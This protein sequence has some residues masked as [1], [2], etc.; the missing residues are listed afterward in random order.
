MRL[1][2]VSDGENI[3]D[4]V[5]TNTGDAGLLVQAALLNGVSI[6]D[7]IDIGTTL[8]VQPFSIPAKTIVLSTAVKKIPPATIADGQ[9]LV[10]LAM[11]YLGDAGRLVELALLNGNSITDEPDTG[12]AVSIPGVVDITKQFIV[13][14]FIKWKQYPASKYDGD[15]DGEGNKLEGIGYWAIA[16]DFIVS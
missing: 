9:V 5:C 10:D 15:V 16:I 12:A 11:Q 14:L 1:I 8:I 2:K 3:L 6:T 4:I 13:D 7:E